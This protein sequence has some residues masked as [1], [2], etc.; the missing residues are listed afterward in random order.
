MMVWHS[1]RVTVSDCEH[2][3]SKNC[4]AKVSIANFSAPNKLSLVLS[5]DASEH[6]FSTQILDDIVIYCQNFLTWFCPEVDLW[7]QIE[8]SCG[9]AV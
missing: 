2:C 9:L 8:V 3:L 6:F 7:H 5:D 4:N 1:L